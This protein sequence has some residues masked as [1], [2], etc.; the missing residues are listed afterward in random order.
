MSDFTTATERARRIEFM[1]DT[2]RALKQGSNAARRAQ[3]REQKAIA[4][5]D[6]FRRKMDAGAAP[7]SVVPDALAELE[8]RIDEAA[9]EVVNRL[10]V[11]L[12]K[13]LQ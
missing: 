5:T 6:W 4:W 9:V 1:Q 13:A 11:E 12:I 2:K 10:K 7:M 3:Q 8:Q